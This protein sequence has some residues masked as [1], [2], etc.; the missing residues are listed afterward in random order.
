MLDHEGNIWVPG[1]IELSKYVKKFKI[2]EFFDDAIIKID[3]RWKN[4]LQQ[5][6]T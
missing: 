6:Y 2:N 3:L 4:S 5:K 1:Q